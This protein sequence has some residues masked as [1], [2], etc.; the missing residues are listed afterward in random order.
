MKHLALGMM[1]VVGSVTAVKQAEACG[2]YRP[3]IQHAER[4]D[5]VVADAKKAED[6]GE[7]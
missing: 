4:P 3:P 6:R 5:S 7:G 2:M 1:M